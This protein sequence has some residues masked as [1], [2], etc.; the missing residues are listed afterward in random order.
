MFC[1]QFRAE[2]YDLRG[3]F[4]ILFY[5][6]FQFKGQMLHPGYTARPMGVLGAPG[7]WHGVV[8]LPPP[9]MS[10]DDRKILFWSQDG[11]SVKVIT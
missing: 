10:D 9:F 8:L 11:R 4:K 5:S 2:T 3:V 1:R 6:L 7:I